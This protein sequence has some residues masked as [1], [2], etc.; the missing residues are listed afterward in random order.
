M[1]SMP[2]FASYFD[3]FPQSSIKLHHIFI[4]FLKVSSLV[5]RL[6]MIH[7]GDDSS[8]QYIWSPCI[9]VVASSG[10]YV[11]FIDYYPDNLFPTSYRQHSLQKDMEL[12]GP[13]VWCLVQYLCSCTITHSSKL[14]FD[15]FSSATERARTSI[16][17]IFLPSISPYLDPIVRTHSRD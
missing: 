16:D 3:V 13:T 11:I 1:L 8:C 7:L 2:Q 9:I 17:S 4:Q 15:G 6:M 10:V 12:D 5:F 14:P